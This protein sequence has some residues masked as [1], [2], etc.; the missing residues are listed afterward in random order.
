MRAILFRPIRPLSRTTPR[1]LASNFNRPAPPP[2]PPEQQQE[3]E[4]LQ[5]A[6][7]APLAHSRTDSEAE[8]ALHPDARKPI[9]PDFEGDINPVTGEQGGPKQEP[10]GKWGEDSEGDWSFKGRVSDF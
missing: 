5:R 2:L 9:K 6:A 10:V 3:F 4:E 7:Q 1:R 8:L